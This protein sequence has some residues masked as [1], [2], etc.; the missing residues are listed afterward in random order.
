MVEK[1]SLKNSWAIVLRYDSVPAELLRQGRV[2]AVAAD[3][4]LPLEKQQILPISTLL[5]ALHTKSDS[6]R[7]REECCAGLVS[8][9]Q[10]SELPTSGIPFR[11]GAP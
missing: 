10:A 11:E 4:Q 8:P 7:E 5:R 1:A 9:W 6:G 2:H 3:C